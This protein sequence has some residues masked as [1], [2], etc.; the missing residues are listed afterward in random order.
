MFRVL[1][2]SLLNPV[3]HSA[4][5]FCWKHLLYHKIVFLNLNLPIPN[6]KEVSI[7]YFCSDWPISTQKYLSQGN[8][9]ANDFSETYLFSKFDIRFTF[10]TTGLWNQAEKKIV[11]V[12]WFP[13]FCLTNITKNNR[14]VALVFGGVTWKTTDYLNI[15]VSQQII[16]SYNPVSWSQDSPCSFISL[17]NESLNPQSMSNISIWHYHLFLTDFL[18]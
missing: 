16:R 4:R 10:I 15:H 2:A 6:I 7:V 17:I 14:K 1:K 11:L 8:N 3:V 5:E 13:S 12:I 18:F 9:I